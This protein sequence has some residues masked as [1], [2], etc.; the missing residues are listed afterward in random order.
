MTQ[1]GHLRD[2]TVMELDAIDYWPLRVIA[3]LQFQPVQNI[4]KGQSTKGIKF[5]S[6]FECYMMSKDGLFSVT[7]RI[8]EISSSLNYFHTAND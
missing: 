4:W 1:E 6:F 8:I 2:I 3:P 7:N 5:A